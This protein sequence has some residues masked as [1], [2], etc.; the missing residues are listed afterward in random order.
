MKVSQPD[1]IKIVERASTIAERLSVGQSPS[2]RHRFI[3]DLAKVNDQLISSRL[4]AW[5]Q[6]V[7]RGNT[8]KFAQRL[9]WDNLN[10]ST[11]S[12]VLGAVQLVNSQHLPAWA[13]TLREVLQTDLSAGDAS[14]HRCLN[15]EDLVPFEEVY[16]PFIQVAR[17]KLIT[18][19][20]ADYSLLSEEAHIGLERSLLLRLAS[21]CSRC[22]ELEF[23]IVRSLKQSSLS[24]ALGRQQSNPA[25][26][27]Y[28]D[29]VNFTTGGLLSFFQK[30]NVLARLAA[31]AT[32]FWL[33]ATHEFLQRLASD[34]PTLQQTFP[35][36][37]GQIIAVQP[38]LSDPHNRG[39]TVI[40]IIFASGLKLIYKPRALGLEVA[41]FELLSWFNQHQAPL[42]FKLLKVIN[43]GT[44]GWMEY[45][46]HLPCADA[47]AAQRYYQRAG[48]L[49]CLLYLL[50]GTDCH[51]ENLIASGEH[52]VLIDME[53]LMHPCV[54]ESDNYSG[55]VGV[56]SLSIQQFWDSVL[57][58]AL[59]P[60]WDFSADGRIAYDISGLGGVGE[61]PNSF[62]IPTWKQVN[63]DNMALEYESSTMPTQANAALLNG[64]T[65]LPSDYVEEIV[66]GFQQMYQFLMEQEVLLATHSPLAALA[67]QQVRWIF[68][69]SKV[70]GLI[71]SKTL[72]PKFLKDGADRSIELDVLSRAFL[73]VD[74]KPRIW[75]LLAVELQAMEQV[76][77]PFF[78]ANTGSDVMTVHPDINIEACFKEPSYDLVIT[79]LK[80]LSGADLALQIAIIRGSLFLRGAGGLGSDAS[81]ALADPESDL[82][83]LAKLTPAQMVQE[84]VVIAQDLQQRAICAPDGSVTWIGM[85]YVPESRRLQLQP[86]YYGLYDGVSGV[87]LFL[88][89]LVKITGDAQLRDL[90]LRALQPLRKML[91]LYPFQPKVARQVGIGSA[92][93]LGSDIYALVRV[94]EFLHEPDLLEVA[95]LA[96]CAIAVESIAAERTFDLMGGVAGAILGLLALHQATLDPDVLA[97][98]IACGNHLLENRIA[99]DSGFR[100]WAT[101]ND[102]L[103]TGFSHGAAG[104]AYALLRLAKITS[105]QVFLAAAEEAIAYERSVFSPTD[106]N[107]PD[108]RSFNTGA[109]QPGFMVSWCHG[110]PGIGLARLGG[111]KMLDTA[112]I[113]QEIAVALNTTQQFGLQDI[114][115]L[116]CGNFGRI[117]VLLVAA[118]KLSRPELLK[119]AQKQATWLVTARQTGGFH[120]FPNLPR[121]VY[122]PGFFQGTAGIGYELLRLAHPALFPSVLLWE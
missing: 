42:P 86:L 95:K 61:Q 78:R 79:R 100:A 85:R 29:F 69:E 55:E 104:I 39:R 122:N 54:C 34:L 76:D 44:Y 58:S 51:Y 11:V 45:V 32:D 73:A 107:W 35:E 17:Q 93:G 27:Q 84:A 103:L 75:P 52:P 50:G 115:H 70:Y 111:L 60:R 121:D 83:A 13:E 72:Q 25:R 24:R 87:A 90:A 89:A 64:V 15:P 2:R 77:L 46:E 1:L 97:Q 106:G 6:A 68:R 99:S 91:Q 28:R 118:Q 4:D 80:Q 41:Y 3:P 96:A 117:E 65:L 116:C 56:L 18:Q 92:T 31:T 12:R 119:T 114:D 26:N 98:A 102:K 14:V 8:E 20:G 21:L 109:T 37:T 33:E 9:A 59:L 36:A 113:R 16:L 57:N 82:E 101:V 63:T 67:H 49:L 43:S 23:S 71:L 74:K 88:A 7:A 53:T 66:D 30:Y 120:L 19:A 112:E 40:A 47:A 108:L 62:Q 110:A 94:S 22:L 10:V 48:M 5:C 81:T 38:M 105:S